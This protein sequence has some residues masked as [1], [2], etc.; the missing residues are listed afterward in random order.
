MAKRKSE[1][2]SSEEEAVESEV[3]KK[4]SLQKAKR[5]K[6]NAPKTVK[7][8]RMSKAD[9]DEDEPASKPASKP[10]KSAGK[11]KSTDEQFVDIGNKRRVTVRMFKQKPLV[12]IREFYEKDG[13]L[14]PGK[15]GISLNIEQWKTLKSKMDEIDEFCE[16]ITT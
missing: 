9:S 4:K 15:K 16:S 14:M 12:D 6:P 13:D 5:S 8:P 11:A 3:E 1:E 7:K 2:T 10:K